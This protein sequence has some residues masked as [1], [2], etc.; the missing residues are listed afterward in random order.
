MVMVTVMLLCYL[1]HVDSIDVGS[2]DRCCESATEGETE[3]DDRREC[4]TTTREMRQIRL[5]HG[6]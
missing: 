3:R 5:R 2:D 1:W 4:A 6:W